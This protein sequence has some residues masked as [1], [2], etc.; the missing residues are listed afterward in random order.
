MF[1]GCILFLT[2]STINGCTFKHENFQYNRTECDL[3]EIP[4]DVP[5]EAKMLRLTNN[6]I[7]AIGLGALSHLTRCTYL[8]L[9]SND[10]TRITADSFRGLTSVETLWLNRNEISYIEAGSF[11]DLRQCTKLYL[12]KNELTT[13]TADMFQGLVELEKLELNTNNISHVEAG[14]FRDLRQCTKLY[15]HKK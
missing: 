12:H 4:P 15:L 3:T 10:I 2:V 14:S 6:R 8:S 13:I 7:S 5:A 9:G 1:V 11:R